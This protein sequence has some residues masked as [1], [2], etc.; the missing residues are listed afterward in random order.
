MDAPA[1]KVERLFG[2]DC[3]LNHHGDE[4]RQGRLLPCS[5]NRQL[6]GR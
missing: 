1:K 4:C 5:V 3:C 6:P 2:V